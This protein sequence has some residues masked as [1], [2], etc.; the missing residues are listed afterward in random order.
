MVNDLKKY[1][2]E[3]N[4]KGFPVLDVFPVKV[5]EIVPQKFNPNKWDVNSMRTIKQS[6]IDSGMTEPL[7]IVHLTDK[8]YENDPELKKKG[9]KWRLVD[10]MHRWYTFK[11]CPEISLPRHNYVPCVELKFSDEAEQDIS[12]ILHN[13]HGE[14]D[15]Q[16][17]VAM[18]RAMVNANMSDKFILTHFSNFVPDQTSLDKL[19]QIAGIQNLV[20]EGSEDNPTKFSFDQ[21]EEW[22]KEEEKDPALKNSRTHDVY[23]VIIGDEATDKL[24]AKVKD[25]MENIKKQGNRRGGNLGRIYASAEA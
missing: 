5:D 15:S 22:Y 7:T 19:K 1:A 9:K 3:Q 20:M 4:P 18:V 17:T 13:T 21:M 8:D 2:T 11:T 6:I 14:N 24:D 10:G 12:T 25:F 16:L 23:R